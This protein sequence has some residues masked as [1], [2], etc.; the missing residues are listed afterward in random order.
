V[1]EQEKSGDSER[2]TASGTTGGG[3]GGAGI[4]DID[5]FVI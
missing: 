3:G 2:L 4:K 5:E 1:N